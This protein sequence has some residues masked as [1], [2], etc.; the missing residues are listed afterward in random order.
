MHCHIS[1]FITNLYILHSFLIKLYRQR[2]QDLLGRQFFY[3]GLPN[4]M[5]TAII[6]RQSSI[7]IYLIKNLQFYCISSRRIK[8]EAVL[9]NDFIWARHKPKRSYVIY[10][11]DIYMKRKHCYETVIIQIIIASIFI[12]AAYQSRHGAINF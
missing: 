7:N 5:E 10:N 11:Y 8:Q 2:R 9:T 12:I 6:D 4:L 3:I 1:K